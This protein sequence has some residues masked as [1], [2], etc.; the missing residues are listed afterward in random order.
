MNNIEEQALEVLHNI[1]W[2][3]E[4]H[5]SYAEFVELKG[6]RLVIRCVGFCTEC[7]KDCIGVAF[8]EKMPDIQLVRL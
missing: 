7:Q 6:K 8:K 4:P 1:N 2:L 5:N 3:M